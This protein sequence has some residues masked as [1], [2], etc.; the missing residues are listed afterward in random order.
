MQ[1]GV[2]TAKV[3]LSRRFDIDIGGDDD[4]GDRDGNDDNDG[5]DEK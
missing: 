3:C 1:I 2:L 4:D 5:N